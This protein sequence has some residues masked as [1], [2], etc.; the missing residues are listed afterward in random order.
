[1]QRVF[2]AHETVIL[3]PSEEKKAFVVVAKKICGSK[4]ETT[5]TANSLGD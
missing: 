1:M 4:S 2:S 5:C 3:V